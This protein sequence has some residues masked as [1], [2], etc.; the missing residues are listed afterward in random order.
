MAQEVKSITSESLEAT[1]RN[2]TPSQTGFTQDLMA[3]NTIVPVLDLT[4]AAEG[5]ST[6]EYLQKAW[7]DSTT[8]SQVNNQTTTVISNTGFW[9]VD[10]NCA[11]Q[12]NVAVAP[13]AT[14]QINDGTVNRIKIWQVSGSASGVAA[15]EN[16]SETFYVFLRTGRSLEAVS[17][18]TDCVMNIWVRQVADVN[19]TLVNPLGFTPQ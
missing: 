5:S 12:P 11:W 17:S 1:Y 4:S 18:S 7:D 15:F 9:K 19:G 2:L 6:P 16:T 13:V 14:V 8:L 10:L 3:S